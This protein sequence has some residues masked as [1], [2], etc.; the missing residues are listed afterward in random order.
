MPTAHVC[1]LGSQTY[2]TWKIC[3]LLGTVTLT[4]RNKSSWWLNQTIWKRCSS[5][6]IISPGKGENK[7]TFELPPPRNC[8]NKPPFGSQQRKCIYF[9][10]HAVAKEDKG[11]LLFFPTR[12]SGHEHCKHLPWRS[13]TSNMLMKVQEWL[14]SS[15]VYST[16]MLEYKSV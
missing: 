14:I 3:F 8:C 16:I 11:E 2:R 9:V 5:N 6:W 4:L 7:K 1:T 13:R 15:C 12:E 10:Y